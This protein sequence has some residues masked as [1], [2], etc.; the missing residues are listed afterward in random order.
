MIKGQGKTIV[1]KVEF[2]HPE[3]PD[4]WF[5]R[6]KGDFRRKDAYILDAKSV[7][8]AIF[9]AIVAQCKKTFPGT[10]FDQKSDLKGLLDD[11]FRKTDLPVKCQKRS[12]EELWKICQSLNKENTETLLA[13]AREL[14]NAQQQEE[15]HAAADDDGDEEED[16]GKDEDGEEEAAWD[17]GE[18]G[19]RD[20]QHARDEDENGGND[21]TGRGEEKK[22]EE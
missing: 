15:V 4:V 12:N 8:L 13:T 22:V 19:A 3:T 14:Q 1:S 7:P 21:K 10:T 9:E 17:E 18:A 11:K 5:S 2:S 20:G 6:S 16:K